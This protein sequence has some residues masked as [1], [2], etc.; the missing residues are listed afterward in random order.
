M[1]SEKRKRRTS[2]T[3]FRTKSTQFTT[4][5]K[6]ASRH[7]LSRKRKAGGRTHDNAA[8]NWHTARRMHALSLRYP[9]PFRRSICQISPLI[10]YLSFELCPDIKI[11]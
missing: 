1:Q 4:P 11:V 10:P 6:S 2:T 5:T 8:N 9:P 7:T 3:K